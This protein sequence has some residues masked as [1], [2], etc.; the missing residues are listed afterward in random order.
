M[1]A[2]DLAIGRLK[3]DEGFK[4]TLYT[5]TTGHRTIGYG[6]NVDAGITEPSAFALLNAQASE[7]AN[8]LQP[9]R[10]F[11]GLDDVRAS[12]LIELAFN[13]GVN[14]L[15]GFSKMLNALASGDYQTAHDQ[16]LDSKAAR[17][18]PSRYDQLATMLLTGVST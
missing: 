1:S 11:Q 17:Q 7:V 3:I 16:L 12:V 15:L 10:G 6:F 14:G 13:L 5:D 8:Q 18:L 2:L 9:M 4:S